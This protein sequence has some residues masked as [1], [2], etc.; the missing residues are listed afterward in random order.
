[1]SFWNFFRRKKQN[2]FS[3]NQEDK[4]LMLTKINFY[5]K[6]NSKERL[7]FELQVSNF[8]NTTK[9]T[10]IKTTVD[11]TD[12]ILIASSAVI[13]IFAFDNW[14]YRNLTEVLLYPEHF[15]ENFNIGS[16]S[17]FILGMVGN[18]AME[19]TMILSK[20][21]LHHGFDNKTDKLNTAV[22]EFIHLIDKADGRIDGLIGGVKENLL[23]LPWLDFMQGKIRDIQKN[24]SDIRTYGATNNAEFLAVAGEYFF[25]RPKLLKKKHP[26]LYGYLSEFFNLP[27][28]LK[29]SS[30]IK[31]VD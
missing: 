21:A 8:L 10:G 27:P 26:E 6:L 23:V 9:I 1:M 20:K 24:K 14:E 29:H 12:R 15:D 30:N 18:G 5:K 28:A 3:I 17:K 31:N 19:G 16:K 7:S 25:E 4:N 22:H 13:P 2:L 11:Q